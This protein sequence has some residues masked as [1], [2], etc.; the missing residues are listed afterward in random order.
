MLMPTA[1]GESLSRLAADEKQDDAYTF[2]SPE[3]HKSQALMCRN[4][5]LLMNKVASVYSQGDDLGTNP[6]GLVKGL[7]AESRLCWTFVTLLAPYLTVARVTG[8]T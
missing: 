2:Q 4:T 3:S 5:F 8:N 7:G 6:L 1:V